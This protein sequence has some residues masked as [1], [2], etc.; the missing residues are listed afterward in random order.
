ME[1]EITYE[2][3]TK[4]YDKYTVGTFVEEAAGHHRNRWNS[5]IHSLPSLINF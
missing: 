5:L 2:Q 3:V 1:L 4:P